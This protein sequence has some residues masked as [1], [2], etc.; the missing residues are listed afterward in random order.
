MEVKSNID[1]R[2]THS[3]LC[4]K[5]CMANCIREYF[6]DG[7]TGLLGECVPSPLGGG[8]MLFSLL[9]SALLLLML[10]VV[11][12]VV[13]VI[14]SSLSIGGDLDLWGEVA[15]LD[16]FIWIWKENERNGEEIRM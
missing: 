14:I 3:V 8:L 6:P 1:E 4:L 15:S 2:D 5:L 12:L 10:L 11:V 9:F 16:A 13:L 7:G